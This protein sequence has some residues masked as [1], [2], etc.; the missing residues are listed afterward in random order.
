MIADF[1]AGRKPLDMDTPY[2]SPFVSPQLDNS[3]TNHGLQ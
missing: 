2:I 1:D 3:G